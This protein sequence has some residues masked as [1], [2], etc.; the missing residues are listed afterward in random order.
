MPALPNK[1]ANT[2][3]TRIWTLAI[4]EWISCIACLL[5]VAGLLFSRALLSI[6]M[7]LMVVNALHPEAIK[8]SWNKIK[9]NA[10]IWCA[11]LFFLSYALSGFWSDDKVEWLGY[12]QLKLPFVF[13]PFAMLG[14]PLQQTK[15]LKLVTFGTL[16]ILLAGVLY[17]FYF[18]ALNFQVFLAGS[19]FLSPVEGDYIRFTIALAL[20]INVAIYVL[21]SKLVASK[22]GKFLVYG[23]IFI[24]V[25][26]LHIQAA[27]SGLASLYI[28]ALIYLLYEIIKRKKYLAIGGLVVAGIVMLFVFL[29]LPVVKS[30]IENFKFEQKVWQTADTSGYKQSMSFV[31]RVIS[32]KIAT[33]LIAQNPVIGVG[34]TD[35]EDAIDKRYDA[36]FPSI[37]GKSRIVPHNQFLYTALAV[38][39][40]LAITLLL[41]VIAP[42]RAG[43]FS[44]VFVLTT[45]AVLLCGLMIEPMLEVQHGVFTYLFFTLL[46]M[47]VF[48]KS[49]KALLP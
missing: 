22:L 6:A 35:M 45:F 37:R 27:K 23:W 4:Q 7:I 43:G 5:M 18:L 14:M 21:K 2:K 38:G 46:W 8:S 40:P 16:Y 44:N 17:S 48:V 11:L 9:K 39:I 33:Q 12:V 26:Y 49:N 28:L 25:A 47:S 41:M 30:Q 19:H 1:M 34:P 15:F 29:S 10:F 32:Y 42:L 13:I 3:L 24:A 36:E 31:P 20:G